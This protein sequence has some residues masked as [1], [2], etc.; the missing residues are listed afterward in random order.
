VE[1]YI[2]ILKNLLDHIEIS[3]NSGRYT[4]QEGIHAAMGMLESCRRTGRCLYICG[5]GGSAGIA[6]HMTAD[7]LKNGGIRTYNMYGQTTL[8]CL[9]N[10]YSYEYVFSKQIEMLA[11]EKDVLIAVS[12]SGES[13]NMIRAIG[14]MR[15]IGGTVMTFTGFQAG[16]R[17]RSLGDLNVY[18]PAEHY[19]MVE[20]VHN[21]IL[22]QLVDMIMETGVERPEQVPTSGN[23]K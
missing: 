9:S 6:Q 22:Q 18:V 2:D 10:D 1:D 17:M 16:N 3:G 11:Q 21:L 23:S 12:S 5:N 15:K 7:F 13:E 8:T 19:G 14:E 20:S 4:Y